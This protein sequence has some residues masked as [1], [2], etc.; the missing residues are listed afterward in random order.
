MKIT[1]LLTTVLF[2]LSFT[3]VQASPASKLLKRLK[4]I[5]SSGI[6]IGHQDA[7]VYGHN[8]KW[9]EGRSDIKDIIGDYPA[10]IGFELGALE[11]GKDKNIDHVPFDRMR[12]EIQQQ[13]ARGGIIELSWHPFNPVTGNNAWDPS[14]RPVKEIIPGGSQHDKFNTWL[15]AV[16]QF[17]SSLRTPDGK[18]IPIIFR[19]WHEM[20]GGWFWWGSAS[21]TPDEYKQL[22]HYTHDVLSKKYKLNNLAWGFSPNA[23][24]ADYLTY[25]PGD[26]YADLL[27]IDLY[28]FD[29]NNDKYVN[30]L[31][32]ELNRLQQVGKAHR[33]VIA[34]TE[35]GAQRL[36]DNTWFTRVFWPAVKDFPISYVLFWRNAWDNHKET[37][38]AYP[39]SNTEQDFRA[40]SS[41]PRTLFL[42]DINKKKK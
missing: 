6:M 21:C 34:L 3:V 33:K 28:D 9:D 27:G 29:A 15:H 26:K 14:G 19:P 1:T 5:Q 32:F 16:A 31:K 7:T 23:G 41:Y 8:W 30:T 38:M 4:K 13:H 42:G 40:F 2:G 10:V 11:L 35:T 25:Y 12:R 39:G 22:Y 17:L 24:D 20:G 18:L 36:P 37:Y